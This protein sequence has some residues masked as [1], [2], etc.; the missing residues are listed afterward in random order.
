[1]FKLQGGKPKFA[2]ITRCEI[3]HEGP[4]P[5]N[6][7]ITRMKFK[8]N[9][10]QEGK[11]KMTYIT[12]GKDILTLKDIVVEEDEDCCSLTCQPFP[13]SFFILFFNLTIYTRGFVF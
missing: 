1:L 4:K 6:L 9:I 2:Q 12:G 13:I 3:F 7:Q 10:L 8:K 11:P 5:K